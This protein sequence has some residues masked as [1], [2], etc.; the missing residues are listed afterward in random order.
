MKVE[1]LP[2]AFAPSLNNKVQTYD[3]LSFVFEALSSFFSL[4]SHR[5]SPSVIPSCGRDDPHWG[6]LSRAKENV[7]KYSNT[8]RQ[9]PFPLWVLTSPFNPCPRHDGGEAHMRF[10]RTCDGRRVGDVRWEWMEIGM[11]GGIYGRYVGMEAVVRGERW[12]LM[13][14]R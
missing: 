9:C 6:S 7:R 2:N 8:G 12:R 1:G 10:E 11:R 14:G 13:V 3:K 4:H 5:K